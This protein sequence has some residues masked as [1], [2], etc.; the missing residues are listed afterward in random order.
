MK[1]SQKIGPGLSTSTNFLMLLHLSM[2]N[3]IMGLFAILTA[4]M[5][6]L[7]ED[8]VESHQCIP[9]KKISCV[10][11]TPFVC[12]PGYLDGCITNQTR[13]HE[14]LPLDDGP[15]CGLQIQLKCPKNFE[16]GCRSGAT[17]YHLCIPSKGKLCSHNLKYSCPVGFVDFCVK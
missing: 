3:F 17:D 16:D 13:K 11:E 9:Q 10:V 7:P 15:S 14:C 1:P 4:S 6:P 5:T 8:M 2:L 12:P